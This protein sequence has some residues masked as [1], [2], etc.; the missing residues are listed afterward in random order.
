L[1]RSV[2]NLKMQDKQ[3]LLHVDVDFVDGGSRPRSASMAV[4]AERLGLRSWQ[5]PRAGPVTVTLKWDGDTVE[6]AR[7]VAPLAFFL[8]N[9]RRA[10]VPHPPRSDRL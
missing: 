10:G 3:L 2:D 5:G 7:P 6:L 4:R 1:Q 8:S 9:M